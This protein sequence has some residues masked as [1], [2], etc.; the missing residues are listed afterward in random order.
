MGISWESELLFRW[1]ISKYGI[2]SDMMKM[3]LFFYKFSLVDGM[4]GVLEYGPWFIRPVPIILK[5]S[6][7][8]ANLLKEDLCSIA[9]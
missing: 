1:L 4:H 7:P 9:V 3:G 6:T 5:N 2:V 8:N